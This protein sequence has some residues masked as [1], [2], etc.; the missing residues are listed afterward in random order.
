MQ[1]HEGWEGAGV[2]FT[3]VLNEAEQ[4]ERLGRDARNRPLPLLSRPAVVRASNA[5][6]YVTHWRQCPLVRGGT[7]KGLAFCTLW[8]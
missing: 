2:D 8:T 4:E 6:K 7:G 5:S 3:G 1:V